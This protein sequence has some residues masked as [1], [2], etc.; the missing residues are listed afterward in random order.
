MSRLRQQST[1][2]STAFRFHRRDNA[3][4]R[5]RHRN[6][7]WRL[8]TIMKLDRRRRAQRRACFEIADGLLRPPAAPRTHESRIKRRFEM[9]ER[10]VQRTSR[11]YPDDGR[12]VSLGMGSPPSSTTDRC[13][14]ELSNGVHPMSCRCSVP[15]LRTRIPEE[16]ARS[17]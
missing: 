8:V 10:C 7:V 9:A 16:T 1:T 13:R 17:A 5:Q 3:L 15:S 4:A 6:P 2:T 11:T 14:A 12:I